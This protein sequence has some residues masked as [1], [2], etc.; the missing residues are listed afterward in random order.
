[1]Y[2]TLFVFCA[3]AFIFLQSCTVEQKLARTFIKE[4]KNESI[5]VIPVD[6][7]Y[8]Y[9]AGAIIDT[10]ELQSVYLQD[11]AAFAQSLYL[12]FI[13]DSVFLENFYN[14]FI[15]T[16]DDAGFDVIVGNNSAEFFGKPE[17]SWI[18]DF[19]Q[20]QLDENIKVDTL[21]FYE[22]E[23]VTYYEVLLYQVGA[24]IWIDISPVNNTESRKQILYKRLYIE[25]DYEVK[26]PFNFETGSFDYS[27][28]IDEI[29]LDKISTMAAISG[30][31]YA[32]MVFDFL[33]NDHLRRNLPSSEPDR[34]LWH[35]DIKTDQLKTGTFEK[36][37]MVR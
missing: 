4:C 15:K 37:E 29:T 24:G 9:N 5:L 8:R 20:L 17:P 21:E 14:T 27:I 31:K 16:L 25:D 34:S 33:L 6:F 1:M 19:I 35:Y 2:R 10:N 12:Q 26:T 7:T 3:T 13:S 18:I 36:L 23:D 22:D 28:K 11:S 30:R 32:G